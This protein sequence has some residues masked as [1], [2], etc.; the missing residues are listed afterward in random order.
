MNI[1]QILTFLG[2]AAQY[3]PAA[4]SVIAEVAGLF[5][6]SSPLPQT[7]PAPT[8]PSSGSP[9]LKAIQSALNQYLGAKLVIDGK[10]GPQTEAALKQA[11][12]KFGISV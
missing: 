8:V 7:T 9:T 6:G 10:Y 2:I 12:Q 4:G 1:T 3:L 11:F 5:K